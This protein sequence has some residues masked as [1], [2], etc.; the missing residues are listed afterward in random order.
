MNRNLPVSFDESSL[1]LKDGKL[2]NPIQVH[3]NDIAYIATS[4]MIYGWLR[5]M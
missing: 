3:N 1:I 5:L 4:N 2:I